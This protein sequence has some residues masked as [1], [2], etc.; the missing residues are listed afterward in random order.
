VVDDNAAP[1]L[2]RTLINQ[3]GG[4]VRLTEIERGSKVCLVTNSGRPVLL[5]VL[6]MPTNRDTPLRLRVTVLEP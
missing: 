1:T 5:T 3:T 6:E 4:R 2:C